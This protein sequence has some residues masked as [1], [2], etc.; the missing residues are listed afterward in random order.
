MENRVYE[1]EIDNAADFP[2]L[3]TPNVVTKFY[4]PGRWTEEQIREEHQFLKEL[5]DNEIPVIAPLSFAGETLFKLDD[6]QL[7]YTI[8]PKKGGRAP[9]EMNIDQLEIMGR[10]LARMHNVGAATPAKS[11]IEIS[12]ES[13]GLQNLQ[14]LI[15]NKMITSPHIQREYQ[16]VV[17][18]I[19]TLATPLFKNIKNIR[20]HGDCHCG[21]VISRADD[22]M[23][24]IDFDDML[25]GPAVQDIWL[26]TPGNDQH[27]IIDRNILLDSYQTMRD[28]NYLELK[29]IEP[30][31]ALRFIHFSAWIAKRWDDPAFKLAFS[32]FGEHHYWE[33]QLNDLMKQKLLIE[34]MLNAETMNY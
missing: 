32:H 26:I 23:F 33:I 7:Y 34:N 11:R 3:I 10:M 5:V 13:F 14:F 16:K 12:P 25:S 31:R 28:F 30:L 22:G 4:R 27:A 2:E 17:E 20:I 19:C 21:N 8:F 9:D 29:L 24:F 6:H 1:I 18:E 15:K